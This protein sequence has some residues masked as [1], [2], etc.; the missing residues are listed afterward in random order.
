MAPPLRA[1]R[2]VTASLPRTYHS[3]HTGVSPLVYSTVQPSIAGAFLFPPYRSPNGSGMVVIGLAGGIASG[4]SMVSKQFCA[5]GAG[6]LDADKAGH[7]VLEMPAVK[8]AVRDRWGESVFNP[9]GEIIRK[10]VAAIVFSQECDAAS[11]LTFLEKLTHPEIGQILTQRMKE[12]RGEVLVLDAPLMFKA[13]WD[14]F[15]DHIIFIDA[16][17]EQRLQ[18]A[19]K[20]GWTESQFTAREA[21]Q[22][23]L[24]WKRSQASFVIDNSSTPE[25]TR[26]Q[27]DRIWQTITDCPQDATQPAANA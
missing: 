25:A 15:C 17:Y 8:Q 16:P 5:L 13:G 10:E 14:Q 12:F 21:A 18:R 24:D 26:V 27:V 22:E 20:R 2:A 4:K 9:Q 1:I 19:R 6:W 11:E 23:T 3:Y 7:Q